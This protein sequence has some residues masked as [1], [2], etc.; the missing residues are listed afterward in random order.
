MNNDNDHLNPSPDVRRSNRLRKP[1]WKVQENTER[2]LK[3][4]AL[5]YYD[6]M[7][8]EDD[9]SIQND[10]QN[11][12]AYLSKVDD[13][14]MYYHQ[15]VHQPDAKEFTKAVVKEIVDHC[16]RKH[17]EIVERKTVPDH[18]EI[19]PPVWSMKRKRDLVTRKPTTT[20]NTQPNFA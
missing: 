3:S 8:D 14:T 20:L 12:I 9:Y 4:Y 6:V 5:T 17:W 2:G 13:D 10:L 11:L 18:C 15:A 19:L 1:E 16:R 7:H